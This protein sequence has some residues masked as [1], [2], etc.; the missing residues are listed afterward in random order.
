MEYG[1]E[2]GHKETIY[3]NGP[4]RYL[5]PA[6][7][8][9][10]H[11]TSL[12]SWQDACWRPPVIDRH[13]HGHRCGDKGHRPEDRRDDRERKRSTVVEHPV[14][15]EIPALLLLPAASQAVGTQMF[16]AELHITQGA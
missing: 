14:G 6:E 15:L 12:C 8:E 16:S 5:Y 4:R 1:F 9:C 11:K 7:K 13:K 2:L 10:R 3:E